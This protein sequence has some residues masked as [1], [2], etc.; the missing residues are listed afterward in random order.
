MT[1]GIYSRNKILET[2]ASWAVP[3]DFAEPFYNYLVYGFEPGGCFTA[4][5]ANDW[6]GAIQRSHPANTVQALKALTGWIQERVPHV[7]RGSYDAVDAWTRLDNSE[8]LQILLDHNLIFEDKKEM[9]LA[10]KG[11][12]TQEP[13]LW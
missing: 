11:I 12:P 13:H 4:I 8:R 2:F 10:L 6:A 3:K 1:V 7:A 9:M 5:L